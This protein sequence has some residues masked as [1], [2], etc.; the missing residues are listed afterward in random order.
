M[1][2]ASKNLLL[3]LHACI[4]MVG[5]MSRLHSMVGLQSP[6]WYGAAPDAQMMLL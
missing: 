6:L 2:P 3:Q 1:V 5:F 4:T